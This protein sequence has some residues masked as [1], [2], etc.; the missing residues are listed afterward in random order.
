MILDH[1]TNGSG[2]LVKLSSAGHAKFLSHGDLH[3]LHIVA[4]PDGL[5][6]RIGKTKVKQ[7]CNRFFPQ[8]VV[9]SKNPRF[10]ESLL[11]SRIQHLGRSQVTTEGLL[12]DD[13]SAVR[14]TRPLQTFCN[15]T[16]QTRRNCKIMRRSLRTSEQLPQ[17]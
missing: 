15:N 5:K 14:A 9:N 7:I 2:L 6:K 10:R 13:S 11:Q 1:I 16:E 8:V 3:T 4:V 12:Y 17:I